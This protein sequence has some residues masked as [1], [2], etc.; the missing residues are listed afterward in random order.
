M[1]TTT[2][3]R[4]G[5]QVPAAQAMQYTIER[6]REA[7]QWLKE[8]EAEWQRKFEVREDGSQLR[9]RS[10]ILA[11]AVAMYVATLAEKN[12]SGHS[13]QKSY[14]QH[15]FID[16]FC[17]L[18]IVKKCQLNRHNRSA[19]ESKSYGFFVSPKDI[20]ESNLEQWLSD[21]TLF[22]CVVGKQIK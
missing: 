19:H 4:Q 21:E 20:L 16:E 17:A 10:R 15:K 1:Q 11:D 18:P 14:Q 2:K 22:V 3:T 8:N 12:G 9:T 13:L 7:L 5:N 6:A